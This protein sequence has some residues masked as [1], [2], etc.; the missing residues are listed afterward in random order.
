VLSEH[1]GDINPTVDSKQVK[2]GGNMKAVFKL[3]LIVALCLW[4]WPA[5][6]SA[7][8]PDPQGAIVYEDDFSNPKKSGLEDNL[9]ATDYARGFDPSGAYRLTLL[10]NDDTHWVLFPAQ[11]YGNFTL[12]LDMRDQSATT[13]G[14]M[15]QGVVV[16]A[17]D[18][19]HFYAV[20]VD[21]RK[22]EYT[23]RKLDG[24]NKW[25]DLITWQAASIIKQKAVVNH[26][27]VDALGDKFTIY[28]NGETL[29]SFSDTSYAKGGFG[30]IAANVDASKPDSHFDNLRIYTT[31]APPA[32]APT[33]APAGGA[34]T[35]L[36]R[37]GQSSGDAALLLGC[38]AL[39][40][41]GLSLW[42]RQRTR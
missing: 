30:L 34:P 5:I 27:R 15:A 2:S 28:L 41:I 10:R 37:S 40:L 9:K 7:K 14:D 4:L 19:T 6:V 22:G 20:L 21:P 3:S 11:S 17:R 31:E 8:P 32:A 24:Q 26:L 12:E 38:F 35:D 16:R 29:G 13:A 23:V 25:S 18:D 1:A 36:P 42:V 39:L 33:A